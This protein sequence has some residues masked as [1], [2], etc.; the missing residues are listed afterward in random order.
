MT[1]LITISPI[2]RLEGH[3]KIDL[4]LD[5]DGNVA[6]AYFQVVELRGFE[7]FCEGRPV[8]E[9]P[10]L[11]PKICGVCPG[12]HHMASAKAADAV[13][14]VQIPPAARKLR[15]LY[16][17][18][19]IAH[20]HL[21][22]FFALG[23]PDF[24]IGPDAHPA[25]RNVL[26]LVETPGK[27]LV[28]DAL[29]HR[30][31]AQEI[32]G[33]I[34]G[35][36]IHPV[37]AVP[38]GMASPLREADRAKIEAMGESMV[39]FAKRCLALFEDGILGRPELV[40][41]IR[42]DAYCLRTHYA[43]LVDQGGR[44][45]YYDGRIKVIDP[46]GGEIVTYEPAAYLDHLAERVEAWSYLK[47]PYLKKVGWR[48][49]V[50]GPES[51]VYRVNSL[52]RL[53][54]A[55]G[56]ATPE[57]Q[58]AY[59][60]FFAFFGTKP[61]H[62][63]LAFH[64]ARLIETMFACEMVLRLARDPEITGTEVRIVPSGKPSEGVG[65]VEAARGTLIHHYVSDSR[66]VVKK[67]N[68]IVATAQNNAA[69]CMSVKKAAQAFIRNG[70]VSEGLLNRVEMAFRAYDPCLAC[71]THTM[72]GRAALELRIRYVDGTVDLLGGP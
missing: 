26:G 64:W 66:G 20:S 42:A 46:T 16:Y 69:M 23:A 21:L 48:G 24:I 72:P 38:G 30:G 17:N 54:V 68:L 61:V 51:G 8:E 29:R 36:P 22:H 11:M 6:D 14:G 33:I 2:T 39:Q 59:E 63:T 67:V 12:A 62:D 18:A 10:R 45:N 65:A 71:A 55:D 47:F 3:G 28:L 56:M 5:N 1:E 27:E 37:A 70:K 4:I 49:L 15:E 60:A 34:A 40:D 35:H 19:H 43:G 9:L 58:S 52:A 31:Y 44:V 13:Y 32:Q 25:R 41:L 57:A 50:D 53:N 7:K